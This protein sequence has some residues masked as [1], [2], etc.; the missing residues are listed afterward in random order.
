MAWIKPSVKIQDKKGHG[1]NFEKL[2]E[3]KT[4]DEQFSSSI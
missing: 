1:W 3:N 2:N 4:K